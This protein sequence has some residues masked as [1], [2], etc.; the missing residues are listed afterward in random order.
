MLCVKKSFASVYP[1]TQARIPLNT[2]LILE[3]WNYFRR[4]HHCSKTQK[5]DLWG[6]SRKR[7]HGLILRKHIL[8]WL[9]R[10]L[11]PVSAIHET[12][13]S[14]SKAPRPSLRRCFR[15]HLSRVYRNRFGTIPFYGDQRIHLIA[16]LQRT[17]TLLSNNSSCPLT[18]GQS[19]LH[20]SLTGHGILTWCRELTNSSSIVN[21]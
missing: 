8:N 9:N 1:Q 10:I 4:L 3:L 14:L 20:Q 7:H 12:F 18:P 15:G 13:S 11:L 6:Y 17:E 21:T 19:R 2:L 16:E 5:I